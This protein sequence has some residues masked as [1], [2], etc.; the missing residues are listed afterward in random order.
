MAQTVE[1]LQDPGSKIQD[2]NIHFIR[3]VSRRQAPDDILKDIGLSGL[4][5]TDDHEISCAEIHGVD[6]LILIIRIIIDTQIRIESIRGT[7]A[8]LLKDKVDL[9]REC[10]ETDIRQLFQLL[11]LA[12]LSHIL[13][14]RIQ[15]CD[16]LVFALFLF[17]HEDRRLPS[18]IGHAVYRKFS[19]AAILRR[20]RRAAVRGLEQLEDL[21]ISDLQ[22]GAARLL[23]LRCQ[24][25]FEHLVAV[26]FALH[27]QTELEPG[28][29][30]DLLIDLPGR[31]LRRE[32]QMY[33]KASS[34]SCRRDQLFHKFGLLSLQLGELIH[35]DDQMR[36]RHFHLTRFIFLNVLVDMVHIGVR[37]QPLALLE[38]RLDRL[39]RTI[40]GLAI[41]IRDRSQK[42]GQRLKLIHHTPALEVNDHK[43]DLI[44]VEQ[45]RHGQDIGL[46][47]LRFSGSCRSCHQAMRS[48]RFVVEIQFHDSRFRDADRSRHRTE[49]LRALPPLSQVQVVY[50]KN[51]QHL[52]HADIPCQRSFQ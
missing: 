45:R 39:Q 17:L 19:D 37:K 41:Y 49:H 16:G 14:D 28:V 50:R 40:D 31:L 12:V 38:F 34:D 4:C 35:D 29:T 23:D 2:I 10:R 13:H 52:E 8:L 30:P 18:C 9:L 42:M 5:R 24:R 27:L 33:S 25:R 20:C 47:D 22:I 1:D 51:V 7:C 11:L 6:A 15:L 43:S 3:R 32:D 44:W 26:L 21:I 36:K 48:V 46:Q